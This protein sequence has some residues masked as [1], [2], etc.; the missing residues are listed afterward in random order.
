MNR[1]FPEL[2]EGWRPSQASSLS[3]RVPAY[4]ESQGQDGACTVGNQNC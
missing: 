4:G 2:E 3:T 1:G